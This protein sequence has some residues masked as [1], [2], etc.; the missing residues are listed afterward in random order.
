MHILMHIF[1][2]LLEIFSS[3]LVAGRKEHF[4]IYLQRSE[5]LQE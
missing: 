4:K 5:R 3:K 1:V 2:V